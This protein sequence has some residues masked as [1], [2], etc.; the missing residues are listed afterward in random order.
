MLIAGSLRTNS[1]LKNWFYRKKERTMLVL[2]SLLKEKEGNIPYFCQKKRKEKK[3]MAAATKHTCI[4]LFWREHW[5]YVITAAQ[6][7]SHWVSNAMLL[8]PNKRKMKKRKKKVMK[9]KKKV[10]IQFLRQK[11]P[12]EPTNHSHTPPR[13]AVARP[14]Q[15]QQH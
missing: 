15:R 9:S 6:Q 11:S 3:K 4:H 13:T 8:F 1:C 14:C 7:L 2:Y 12:N 5:S 10:L